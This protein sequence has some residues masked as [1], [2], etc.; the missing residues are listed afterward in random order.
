MFYIK[1]LYLKNFCQYHESTFDF[2][3]KDGSPYNFIS[4]FGP[5][6]IGKSHLLEAISLL[7]VDTSSRNSVLVNNSLQKYIRNLNYDP[8]YHFIKK[9]DS[10]D[11]I[12]EGTFVYQDK[13]YVIKINQD[14]LVRDDF[15]PISTDENNI[16]H[17]GPFGNDYLKYKKR[18]SHFVTN[19]TLKLHNFQIHKSHKDEF[20]KIISEITRYPVRCVET[21]NVFQSNNNA[22]GNEFYT[23]VVLEK[24]G[25]TIHYKRMSLGER[26]ICKSFSDLLNLMVCLESDNMKYWPRILLMDEIESHVYYDRH[27]RF[28]DCLKQVFAKQQ[29]F[30]TTHSGILVPRYLANQHDSE[31]ELWINL[32]NVND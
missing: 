27:V 30:A 28:I 21:S 25:H 32:E 26:K 14:G 19:D 31:N 11:M 22:F 15:C 17:T 3:K 16:K 29:I 20:E 13:D 9:E 1:K 24:K 7:T 4:F 23:D 12:I 2:T 6:G 5:N 18:M 10:L 8:L